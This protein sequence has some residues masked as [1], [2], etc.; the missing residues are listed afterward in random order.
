MKKNMKNKILLPIPGEEEPACFYVLEQTR[1]GG[2]SYLL[3]TDREDGD[4]TAWILKDLSGD[5]DKEAVYEFV[6]DDKELEAVSSV[7]EQLLD[8]VEFS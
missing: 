3:V 4:S 7:F 5:E 8:D 2:F 6:E 1:L